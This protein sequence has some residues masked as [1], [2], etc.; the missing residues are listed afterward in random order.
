MSRRVFK[1]DTASFALLYYY[2]ATGYMM[3]PESKIN[4][5]DRIVD[6]NLDEMNSK[7][8]MIHP[9]N[10]S[11]LIYFVTWDE[12]HNK[13]YILKPDIDIGQARYDYVIGTPFDVIKAS[14]MENALNSLGL[15]LED[16]KIRIIENKVKKLKK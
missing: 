10:N 16:G 1:E 14:Q 11:K 3:L 8:N 4:S 15:K 13:Y 5:Y 6:D 12:N 2:E 7:I 9:I